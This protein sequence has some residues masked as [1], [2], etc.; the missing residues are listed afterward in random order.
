MLASTTASESI[1]ENAARGQ[2]ELSGS[3]PIG[4][5]QRPKKPTLLSTSPLAKILA[6]AG[7]GAASTNLP[8]FHSYLFRTLSVQAL[9]I[10]LFI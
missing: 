8:T 2:E 7:R 10:G 6:G 5:K 9:C 1:S 3:Q 4:Q